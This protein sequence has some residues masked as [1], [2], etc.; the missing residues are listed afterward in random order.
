MIKDDSS[1]PPVV[2]AKGCDEFRSAMRLH[3]I[4]HSEHPFPGYTKS[5]KGLYEKV[6]FVK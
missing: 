5:I 1:L 2:L 6:P 3:I 4:L